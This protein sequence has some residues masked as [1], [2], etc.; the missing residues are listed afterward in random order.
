LP[1]TSQNRVTDPFDSLPGV[2]RAQAEG[3]LMDLLSRCVMKAFSETDPEILLMLRLV[4]IHGVTQRE[5]GRMWRWH[6]SKVSR[7][8]DHAGKMIKKRVL[9][10]VKKTDPWLR[11]AWEDFSDLCRYL[12]S[13]FE[14]VEK[15]SDS[16]AL[17]IQATIAFNPGGG[18]R[19]RI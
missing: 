8:L 3:L 6:E 16:R 17:G 5:I 11:L 7:S 18:K 2:V 14:F 19:D 9:A 1:Q 13:M 10:E 12:P 4:H 15:V